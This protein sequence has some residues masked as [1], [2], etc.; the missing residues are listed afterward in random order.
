MGKTRRRPPPPRSCRASTSAPGLPPA[1]ARPPPRGAGGRGGWPRG[2]SPRELAGG[3]AR[4]R[5]VHWRH[6][7]LA[8]LGRND[9]RLSRRL[10][11]RVVGRPLTREIDPPRERADT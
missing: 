6:E 9:P 7:S 8:L 5:V 1:A 2:R 3:L 11:P 10:D 4:A